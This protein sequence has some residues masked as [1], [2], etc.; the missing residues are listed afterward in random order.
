MSGGNRTETKLAYK[1]KDGEAL[2]FHNSQYPSID[3]I[4]TFE[5][6]KPGSAEEILDMVKKEQ[7]HNHEIERMEAR[8]ES[9][10]P[11]LGM[12]LAVLMFVVCLGLGGF[13]ICTGKD[14]AGYAALLPPL[15]II[16]KSLF[17]PS[18]KKHPD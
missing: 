9:Y 6:Y 8:R 10:I 4:E 14:A 18:Q 17:S 5:R 11:I 2:A 16:V 1:G 3:V 12:S 7:A 13:L 15:A